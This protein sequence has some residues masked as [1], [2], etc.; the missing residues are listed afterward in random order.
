MMSLGTNI[1]RR[2]T[3]TKVAKRAMRTSILQTA[4]ESQQHNVMWILEMVRAAERHVKLISNTESLL[5]ALYIFPLHLAMLARH[6]S[7]SFV[8]GQQHRSPCPHSGHCIANTMI[9]VTMDVLY[10]AI[11]HI[12]TARLAVIMLRMLHNITWAG[13]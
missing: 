8:A 13:L 11:F 12:N 3:Q 9:F 6:K 2:D 7:A 4:L 1:L 5:P 10:H